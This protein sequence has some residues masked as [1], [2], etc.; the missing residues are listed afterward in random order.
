MTGILPVGLK[1]EYRVEPLGIGTTAPRLS[2]T[3]ESEE[4][5]QVQSAY[6]VLVAASEEDLEAGTLL[7][8]SGR[9][10][11]NRSVGIE[12]EGAPLRSGQRCVWRVHVW[13]GEGEPSSPSEPATF[14]V[15]LLERSDW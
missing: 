15:G 9:V 7:W 12:Y 5:S 1:C 8:D 10:E 3:L 2:W 13:D 11:S 4:R 14:E 6:R